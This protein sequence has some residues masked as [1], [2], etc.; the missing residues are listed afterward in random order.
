VH[1]EITSKIRSLRDFFLI[2]FFIIL[3]AGISLTNLNQA[4]WPA[5]LLSMFVLLIKPLIT[6]VSLAVLGFKSR[7]GFL[8]SLSLGQLSEF[9]LIMLALVLQLGYIDER[10]ASIITLT[11]IITIVWSSYANVYAIQIFEKMRPILHVLEFKRGSAERGLAEIPLK[12]HVILIGAH[13]LGYQLV[14]TLSRMKVP[15]IIVDQDPEVAQRYA[16]Q[17]IPTICGD[18]TDSHIQELAGLERAKL[19]I[20]TMPDIHDNE[21]IIETVKTN[22]YKA[23]LIITAQD[24]DD[25]LSLYDKDIDYALLPHFVGGLHLAKIL[26]EN[27][28]FHSLKKLKQEQLKSLAARD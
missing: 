27:Q 2:I 4:L 28:V 17:N 10:T 19:V 21:S 24:E 12:N 9:S 14:Q 16:A 13:R 3:G 26:E 11:A 6:M 22:G 8:T 7:T 18:M 1:Y 23:K 5:V 25:A 15:F 20:S